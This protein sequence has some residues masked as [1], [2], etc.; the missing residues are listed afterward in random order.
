[1]ICGNE[2]AEMEGEKNCDN[3]IAE[4]GGKKNCGNW[5]VAM[6]L[7][8]WKEKKIVINLSLQFQQLGCWNFFFF[9]FTNIKILEIK[10]KMGQW[11]HSLNSVLKIL[12]KN[13]RS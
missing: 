11:V 9:F 6:L 12:S 10:K 7:S 5:F 2:I 8:Q 1:M 3:E 4:M 13:Q